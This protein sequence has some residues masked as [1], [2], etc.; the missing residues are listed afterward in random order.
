MSDGKGEVDPQR[1]GK[2]YLKLNS[3]ECSVVELNPRFGSYVKRESPSSG[4]G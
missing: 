1:K 3:E 4:S 2:K